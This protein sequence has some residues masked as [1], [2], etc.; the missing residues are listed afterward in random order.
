M[1]KEAI[2]FLNTNC[3]KYSAERL[4]KYLF[5]DMYKYKIFNHTSPIMFIFVS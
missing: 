1:I 2:L 3:E 4:F 5:N